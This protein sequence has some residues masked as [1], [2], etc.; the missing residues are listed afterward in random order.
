MSN[1][2]DGTRQQILDT[3]RRILRERGPEAFVLR[4]VAERLGIRHGNVQYY[5]RTRQELL[6]AVFDRELEKYTE[7]M[8]T[9]VAGKKTRRDR[10]DAIVN[11]GLAQLRSPDTSLWWMMVAMAG[12][13]REMA[14]ILDRENSS[15]QKAVAKELKRIAPSLSPQRRRHVAVVIQAM[16]DGISVQRMRMSR[17]SPDT[18]A[19]DKQIR[20]TIHALVEGR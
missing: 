3:A 15:Y 10:L 16:I 9:A 17:K 18:R 12:H 8:N 1:K 14:A 5:F 19:V 2:G 6:L 13:S 20:A 11:S 7:S 4:E